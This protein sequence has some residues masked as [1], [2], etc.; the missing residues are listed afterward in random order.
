MV[1][2]TLPAVLAISLLFGV[3]QKYEGATWLSTLAW[4]AGLLLVGLVVRGLVVAK[5][6]LHPERRVA[7]PKFVV[8]VWGLLIAS[9]FVIYFVVLR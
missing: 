6:T 1:K 8:L 3:Q 7:S 9:W 5:A 4:S 2:R